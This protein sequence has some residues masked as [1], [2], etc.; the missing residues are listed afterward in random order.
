MPPCGEDKKED[1]SLHGC[2][3]TQTSFTEVLNIFHIH[4]Y[5]HTY[6]DACMHA[7]IHTYVCYIHTNTQMCTH[8]S[9]YMYMHTYVCPSVY[10]YTPLHMDVHLHTH[11]RVYIYIYTYIYIY[12]TPPSRTYLLKD[13]YANPLENINP[14]LAFSSRPPRPLG[15]SHK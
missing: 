10:M 5:V 2:H 6:K 14:T 7:Y 3:F 8:I 12:A 11:S 4:T 1:A 13:P 15:G 9:G